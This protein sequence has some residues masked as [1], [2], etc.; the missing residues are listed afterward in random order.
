ML[1]G[2]GESGGALLLDDAGGRGAHLARRRHVHVNHEVADVVVRMRDV[3][4]RL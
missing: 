2:V 3:V 4:K 1:L